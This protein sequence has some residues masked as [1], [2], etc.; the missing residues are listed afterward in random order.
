MNLSN[1]FDYDGED[2][3]E[4]EKMENPAFVISKEIP[5][6][7]G[8]RSPSINSRRVSKILMRNL[9]SNRPRPNFRSLVSA[10]G[11]GRSYN[12]S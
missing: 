5:S 3:V 11:D 9:N 10:N 12:M 8:E 6:V 2:P 4:I 7:A 1:S